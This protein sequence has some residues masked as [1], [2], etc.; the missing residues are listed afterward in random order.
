MNG[1]FR[2]QSK[3]VLLTFPQ[4]EATKEEALARVRELA[5]DDLE[6]AV[7]CSE[8]HQDGSPHLH[9]VL[10]HKVRW[11][12][13]NPAYFD[14]I[15][16]KHG[17]YKP[18]KRGP[19]NLV[20]ALKYVC[21][22]G[23]FLEHEIDVE[24]FL[25]AK[26]AKK[27]SKFT[28][29]ARMLQEGADV[30]EVDLQNPGFVLQ[31]LQKVQLYV[32]LQKKLRQ[33]ETDRLQRI[34]YAHPI[35]GSYPLSIRAWLCDNIDVER[36]LGMKNL[37]VHGPTGLGK[38]RFKE[39]LIERLRVY[40]LPYD[41]NWFDGYEDGKYDL[42]VADEFKGNYTPQ[43]MNKW[44]GSE[45]TVFPRRG[46]APVVKRDRL[47]VIVLANY[48]VNASFKNLDDDNVGLQAL[49]RRV[50]EVYVPGPRK[51]DMDWPEEDT[52]STTEEEIFEVAPK[53]RKAREVLNDRAKAVKLY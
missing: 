28:V 34:P 47:P 21:K 42:V 10:A 16:G 33:E 7:I 4:C 44:C 52:G 51:I 26:A 1:N 50:L 22:D 48:S 2:L 24:M 39:Q 3:Y 41:S 6:W 40:E 31:N 43:I 32:D 25:K 35:I 18:I 20:A 23:D 14:G 15:G 8:A 45:W 12:T 9:M 11:S 30:R 49:R 29:V 17:D 5:S 38:T 13:R 19:G 46:R 27:S 37:W 36:T 53:K